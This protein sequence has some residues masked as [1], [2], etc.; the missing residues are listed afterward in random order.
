MAASTA[1]A[2]FLAAHEEDEARK[3]EGLKT[4]F[5]PATL[6]RKGLCPVSKLKGETFVNSHSL[7]YEQHGRGPQ[8]IVFVMGLNNTSFAWEPLVKHFAPDP[9]YSLVVFDNRGVGN[10][11]T[12][13]GPYSTSAMAED[14][15]T[16]V[17]YIGW[18]DE[19]QLHIVGI[20]LGGMISQEMAMRIPGRIAS[21][22]LIVTTP[23]NTPRP[24]ANFAPTKGTRLLLKTLTIKEPKDKVP[25]VLD[26]IYPRSYLDAPC[27]TMPGK[28]NRD[29]QME[30]YLRRIAH[31]RPQQLQGM[32][33]QMLAALTHHVAPSSLRTIAQS[34]PKVAILTGDDDNM[35][36]PKNSL[37]IK[38]AM[39]ESVQ[40]EV[41]EG[42]G[43]GVF[44]QWPERTAAWLEGVFE[45]GWER[46]AKERGALAAAGTE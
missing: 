38:E 7:Y 32:L 26:M 36:D 42:T 13:R 12:P 14:A 18:T 29:M 27:P 35:V 16:L 33:S 3:L 21:L 40:Y 2:R 9:K 4:L 24:F 39:G 28:T 41:W 10:S 37:R 6:V 43:H 25:Y 11:D 19:R 8:K 15:I 1:H 30:A 5:D 17:D 31:T 44:A 22:T 45:E 34:I 23:G 46:S 20:S